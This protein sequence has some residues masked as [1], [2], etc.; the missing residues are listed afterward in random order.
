MA[1]AGFDDALDIALGFSPQATAND[2]QLAVN[3][4]AQ[5][6]TIP[7]AL[8]TLQ[9][10]NNE[11]R[12]WFATSTLEELVRSH[13]EVDCTPLFALLWSAV[14]D[15]AGRYP[16]YIVAKLRLVL[17][18]AV[19]RQNNL[20]NFI[21]TL[22][23]T[24]NSSQTNS[25]FNLPAL[26]LLSALCEE[27]SNQS[28]SRGS[29]SALSSDHASHRAQFRLHL[30]KLVD[31][32]LNILKAI[33]QWA[34]Q[35]G[36]NLDALASVTLRIAGYLCMFDGLSAPVLKD[37]VCIL[38]EY[39]TNRAYTE[40]QARFSLL[41]SSCT[42][43]DALMTIFSKKWPRDVTVVVVESGLAVVLNILSALS[44]VR[45][46]NVGD[47]YLDKVSA[48]VEAYLTS[49]L[50]HLHSPQFAASLSSLLGQVLELT[51]HQPH[52]S[53]LFHCLTVWEVFITH[54]EDA[55]ESGAQDP[56]LLRSYEKGLVGVMQH[57]VQRMLYSSN[58]AQL[59]ELDDEPPPRQNTANSADISGDDSQEITT[60]TLQDQGQ[61]TA[62][63]SDLKAFVFECF[64]LT[65]RI[66]K[67]PGCAQP[68]LELV[69]PAVRG[70][71]Q[72]FM[73]IHT[74]P[75]P[76]ERSSEV[77]AV[78][79]LTVSCA[80]L[81]S[82]AAQHYSN[83]YVLS[84][85]ATGW[86]ILLLFIQLAEYTVAHRLHTRGAVYVDFECEIL[87]CVRQSTS[88]VPFVYQSGGS[89]SLKSAGESITQIVLT[90]L[91]SSIVPSPQTVVQAALNLLACIGSVFPHPI[92]DEIPS[93][94]QLKT[95][96]QRFGLHLPKSVQGS[97]YIAVLNSIFSGDWNQTAPGF[98][99]ILS[100]VLNS[101][102]ESIVTMQQ[103]SH[104]VVEASLFS[105]LMRDITVVRSISNAIV[106]KPKVIKV[107]FYSQI[108]PVLPYTLE[109]LRL[110]LS[111]LYQ[112]NSTKPQSAATAINEL[113]GLYGDLFRS[114]RKE[115][116]NEIVTQI[117][118]TL[119]EL[120]QN[121]QLALKLDELGE[122]GTSILSGFL[123]LL[124]TLVE[125]STPTTASLLQ[126]IL[127]LCFGSLNEVIFA[128]RHFDSVAPFFV[129]L[130]EEILENHYRFFVV[131]RNTF[132]ENG[133]RLK[134][135]PNELAGKY[136]AAILKAIVT[137]L[138][139][140]NLPPP[141]CKQIIVSL[142]RIHSSHYLFRF[143]GFRSEILMAYVHTI[144]NLLTSGRFT[145]L[146]EELSLLLYHMAQVDMTSF[147]QVCLPLYTGEK[148]SL[149]LRCW[150]GQS[151]EPTF[152]KDLGNFLND[153]KVL[154][155]F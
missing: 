38:G 149:S 79:D 104:R 53:G 8:H 65:R 138:Q 57:L 26:E 118:T 80:L 4:L 24:A 7:H 12:L 10:T 31:L 107:A 30:E 72:Q 116:P 155:S 27:M 125:E 151:D 28:D 101:L 90:T 77:H 85:K 51:I 95:N 133:Q 146:T 41:L 92:Q 113:I 136:F 55:E 127:E 126:S 110:Y 81:S 87:T 44:E 36:M 17:V 134:E 150:S 98:S 2:R 89:D 71:C 76:A 83:S 106:V 139:Q 22:C 99:A 100:P 75:I 37:L 69:L 144:L 154:Q 130:M 153:I 91:D 74:L 66:T 48:L 143:A 117:V 148:R 3:F 64:S 120:F 93:M 128:P 47:D 68:L 142:E 132:D 42:A 147:Y 78:H 70:N 33:G 18:Y 49:H 45:I 5:F 25:P 121:T 124:R 122:S 58:Q 32:T 97:L 141:V 112:N 34:S 16:N 52:T 131:T 119:V 129:S 137:I 40:Q 109:V 35:P 54:V 59:E 21:D 46:K 96:M 60:G 29:F 15:P 13:P 19:L 20:P 23:E 140:E 115:L 6:K 111:Y 82:V 94:Q 108:Q 14:I 11:K 1:D 39:A 84:D 56:Q 86:D 135:Y 152:L 145:L 43:C 63:L 62:E 102:V 50:R 103:N 123:K 67:L 61:E 88:C 105:Q 114:I 73:Q 9:T